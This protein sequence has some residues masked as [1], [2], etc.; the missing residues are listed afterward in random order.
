MKET[1]L[2]DLLKEKYRSIRPAFG[3]PACPDHRELTKVFRLLDAGQIGMELTESCAIIP[4]ASV[5]GLYFGHPEANYFSVGKVDLEQVEDYAH[6]QGIGV[7]EAE[8]HLYMNLGYF[9]TDE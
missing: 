7:K 3:Y 8:H 1:T 5:S 9:P 6:R 4:A 2:D